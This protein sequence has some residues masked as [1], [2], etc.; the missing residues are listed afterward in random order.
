MLTAGRIEGIIRDALELPD[1][2]ELG[3]DLRPAQVPGWDS[4]AWL[5]IIAAVEADIGAE[6]PLDALDDVSTVGDLYAVLRDVA[7][8]PES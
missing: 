3:E 4:L 1:G 7:D 6:I 8:R 2:F 5:N